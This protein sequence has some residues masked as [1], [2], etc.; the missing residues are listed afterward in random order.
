M[1]LWIKYL[2]VS[3]CSRFILSCICFCSFISL[4]SSSRCKYPVR[5]G[6]LSLSS[7]CLRSCLHTSQIPFLLYSFIITKLS[8]AIPLPLS[9]FGLFHTFLDFLAHKHLYYTWLFVTKTFFLANVLKRTMN[10]LHMLHSLVSSIATWSMRL[11]AGMC[12]R[13]HFCLE[14]MFCYTIADRGSNK[15]GFHVFYEKGKN[16]NISQDSEKM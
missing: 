13:S 4:L 5:L 1:W 7:E 14:G 2:T 10:I 12:P 9:I 8:A 15:M 6:R 3:F 16:A 11:L